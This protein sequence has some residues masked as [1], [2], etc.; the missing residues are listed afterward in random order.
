MR[1]FCCWTALAVVV[2]LVVVACTGSKKDNAQPATTTAAEVT[3]GT[4]TTESSTTTTE[5]PSTTLGGNQGFQPRTPGVLTVG[6]ESFDP[7]YYQGS[8]PQT[9]TGGFEYD[10]AQAMA[11]RLRL[12]RAVFVRSQFYEMARGPDCRCDVLLSHVPITDPRAKLVDFT[13][14]YLEANKGVLV[15]SGTTVR[16]AEQARALRWA[17]V[18]RDTASVAL[19]TD[20]VKPTGDPQLFLDVAQCFAALASG[21]VDAVLYDAPSVLAQA[22]TDPRVVVAAQLQT[23]QQYATVLRVGSANTTELDGVVSSLRSDGTVTR[24]AQ[25]WFGIDPTTVPVLPL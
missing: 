16:T 6:V 18:V 8:T 7:P 10:L 9:V 13:Q 15:R 24:L 20:K 19:L 5:A 22:F 14:P 23:G 17:A 25:R 12:S 2:A 4:T 21:Q 11:V 3:S 1:R